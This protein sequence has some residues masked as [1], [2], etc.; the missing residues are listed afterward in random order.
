MIVQAPP[1]VQGALWSY[2]IAKLD[3]A[4]DRDRIVA[5]ILTHGTTEAVAWLR[6][7]YSNDDL[8]EVVAHPTPGAWDERSLNL[9]R[10][11]LGVPKSAQPVR[12]FSR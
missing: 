3:L 11:V 2:D 8:R 12:T 6:S 7:V 5:N 1:S 10:I 9:W 4:R